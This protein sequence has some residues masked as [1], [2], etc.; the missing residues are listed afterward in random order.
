MQKFS[1]L[2]S[3]FP[4][5]KET[6]KIADILL[7]KKL[8]ACVNIIERIESKYWWKGKIERG[9]E[10]LA[11]IKTRKNLVMEVIKEIKK[12]HSYDV[13]EVIELPILKG[14]R[15]YLKWIDEITK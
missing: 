9:K 7:K 14:N 2:I 13:P 4:N 6:N 8:V 11:I 10:T 3:T 12:N 5:K 15:D 1:I